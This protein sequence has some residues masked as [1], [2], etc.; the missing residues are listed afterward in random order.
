M[1]GT[2]QAKMPDGNVARQI[3]P[4]YKRVDTYN[5]RGV[6]VELVQNYK[7]NR[8]ADG[9]FRDGDNIIQFK[10]EGE[11]ATLSVPSFD[12][13]SFRTSIVRL[14]DY[15]IPFIIQKAAKFEQEN[16]TSLDMQSWV[17]DI[18]P[19]KAQLLTKLN[20]SSVANTA[21]EIIP[22]YKRT[23][24]YDRNGVQVELVQN[25]AENELVGG[26]FREASNIIQ[27]EVQNKKCI[28]AMPSF[29]RLASEPFVMRVRDYIIPVIRQTAE[30]FEKEN[31]L[32]FDLDG[33]VEMLRIERIKVVKR[34]SE[35]PIARK[36][37]TG[38]H[39]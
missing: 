14:R 31:G 29:D 19:E 4:L 9:F 23:E 27:F 37:D 24:I 16:K 38:T 32:K 34:L 22:L 35:L 25:Y 30:Q 3:I 15:V 39:A 33:W 5:M 26:H 7:Q 21:S 6:K 11:K 17:A 18:G 28:L 2:K 12:G 36:K 10:V 20:D 8:L 1:Q 13:P